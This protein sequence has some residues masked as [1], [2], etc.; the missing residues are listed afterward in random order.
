MDTTTAAAIPNSPTFDAHQYQKHLLDIQ[1]QA[2]EQDRLQQGLSLL[3][4]NN[5]G[6]TGMH[7][8]IIHSQPEM[9]YRLTDL[10]TKYPQLRNTVDD[11]NSLYQTPLHLAVH[12]QQVDVIKQLLLVGASPFL[13]D[14]KGNTPLHIASSLPNTKSL[15]ELLKHMS[16]ANIIKAAA[17]RNY[18]GWTC[19]HTA[20]LSNNKEA[21]VRLYTA[22]VDM[23]MKVCYI[24]T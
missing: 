21:L 13:Q 5:D 22:D 16:Q 23:E 4:P 10:I 1:K 2:V 11:Q 9:I 3:L 15:E 20:V 17:I 12:L 7:L 8:A 19:T 24:I 14:H 18:E 6:D